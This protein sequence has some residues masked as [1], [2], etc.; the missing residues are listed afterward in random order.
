[1]AERM[2]LCFAKTYKD[3]DGNE[4]TQWTKIGVLF[5]N[6][7]G[8]G[9]S[10]AIEMLPV[11]VPVEPGKPGIRIGARTF[12]DRIRNDRNFLNPLHRLREESLVD[13]GSRRLLHHDDHEHQAGNKPQ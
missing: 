2:D 10:G 5:P 7:N 4:K 12:T 8:Q 6:R 11:G 13:F 1:M 9:Y 3:R